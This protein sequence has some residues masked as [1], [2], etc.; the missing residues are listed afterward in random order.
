[1]K[2]QSAITQTPAT[3][4]ADFDRIALLPEG[5][6]WNHNSHYHSFLLRHLPAQIENAL[7][8]GC[9]AGAFSRLLAV[10]SRHVL[11]IDLSPEMLRLASGASVVY[12]N[13]DYLQADVMEWD[14]PL[15]RFDCVASIAT[16]HH[17]P[18]ED[19]LTKMRDGLRPGGTI[20]VLDLFKYAGV[21]EMLLGGLA[22][23]AGLALRL[24]KRT[25]LRDPPNVRQAWEEH[26]RTDSYLTL[27]E[28]RAI[29]AQV[30]PGAKVRRHLLYRYS[31]VWNKPWA[32]AQGPL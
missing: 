11:G 22:I 10:R 27:S 5:A 20:L 6:G 28:I 31:L 32:P 4:Q 14:F 7:D 15:K 25:P 24:M 2:P 23:P 17:L 3:I 18:L 21:I 8:I 19:V 30:L 29:C 12:P 26:G 1:V 16:L 13:I 9:G